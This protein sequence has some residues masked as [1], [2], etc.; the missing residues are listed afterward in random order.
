MNKY[1]SRE[2]YIKARRKVVQV[3]NLIKHFIAF[4]MANI[5]IIGLNLLTNPTNLWYYWVSI[6]W[7]GILIA[8]YFY[9]YDIDQ[10]IFNRDW[11]EKHIEKA[12][13]KELR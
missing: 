4:V 5:L 1:H 7:I 9:V 13:E 8:H 6:P 11:E 3:K 2:A 12:I 10:M